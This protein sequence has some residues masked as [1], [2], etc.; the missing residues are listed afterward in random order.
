MA[1][2]Q[3]KRYTFDTATSG[4][5]VVAALGAGVTAEISKLNFE[6]AAAVNVT[7]S[8]TSGSVTRTF[9]A[10]AA[11]GY[12]LEGPWRAPAANEAITITLSGAVQVSGEM[13]VCG[14]RSF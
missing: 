4:D 3:G 14:V 6:T 1:Q 5:T 11:A 13:W 10:A 12:D 7:F 9:K 8:S 2:G